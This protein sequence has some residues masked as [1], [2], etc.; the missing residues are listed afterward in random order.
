MADGGNFKRY[1]EDDTREQPEEI[2]RTLLPR[3][4]KAKRESDVNDEFEE[5]EV[6]VGHRCKVQDTNLLWNDASFEAFCAWDDP[7]RL[8]PIILINY[9]PQ[10]PP[11]EASLDQKFHLF[12]VRS[13]FV[14]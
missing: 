9:R 1:T 4:A 8:V 14:D 7:L 5:K 3:M 11:E 2:C 6:G 13:T 10:F 12:D